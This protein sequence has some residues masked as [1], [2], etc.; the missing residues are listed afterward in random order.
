M[1]VTILLGLFAILCIVIG[2]PL[3]GMELE[4]SMNLDMDDES[5]KW[6]HDAIVCTIAFFPAILL[7]AVLLKLF[8]K[9]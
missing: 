2:L 3:I 5:D 1:I 4:K 9:F 6:F 7:G 8:C